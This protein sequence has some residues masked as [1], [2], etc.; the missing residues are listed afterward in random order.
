VCVYTYV[1]TYIHIQRPIVAA[2]LQG[3]E[4]VTIDAA[5]SK[6]QHVSVLN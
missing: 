1:R 2:L 5:H 3:S 4:F 6:L